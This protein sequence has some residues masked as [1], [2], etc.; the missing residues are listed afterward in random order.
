[1]EII[2]NSKNQR[3]NLFSS[4]RGGKSTCEILGELEKDLLSQMAQALTLVYGGETK[5]RRGMIA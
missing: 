4:I 1:M 5:S 2:Y 3:N